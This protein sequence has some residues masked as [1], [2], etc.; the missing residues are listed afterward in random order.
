MT[1]DAVSHR[2]S[3]GGASYILVVQS[4]RE[5]GEFMRDALKLDHEVNVVCDGFEVLSQV[6]ARKPDLVILDL[7]LPGIPGLE[8][9][10]ALQST[11]QNIPIIVTIDADRRSGNWLRPSIMGASKLL[12]KPV[13]ASGLAKWVTTVL[14]GAG[15][16]DRTLEADDAAA[17]LLDH[18][19][20]RIVDESEFKVLLERAQ[21]MNETY[22]QQ[23]T[24]LLL[25]TR[26]VA[27]RDCVTTVVRD[28]LRSGD[29]VFPF[30]T[31]KLAVLLPFTERVRIPPI[32]ERLGKRFEGN[33]Y[34]ADQLRCGAVSVDQALGDSDWSRR[35]GRLL[36][37]S[38]KHEIAFNERVD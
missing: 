1:R 7:V 25:Q 14:E 31:D 28:G 29:F 8:V 26:N 20:P 19:R 4:E 16:P 37:W 35:F 2:P 21:R 9:I 10:H 11:G 32:L 12:R 24:V 34:H 38:Q 30:R 23:S 18:G 33:G 15:L 5:D 6:L 36:S 3:P 27:L 17:L 13:T 22:N